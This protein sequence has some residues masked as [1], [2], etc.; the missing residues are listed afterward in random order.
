MPTLDNMIEKRLL[1]CPR[2]GTTINSD[3]GSFVCANANC[4]YSINPFPLVS[5]KPAFIDFDESVVDV[6]RLIAADGRSELKRNR[7]RLKELLGSLVAGQNKVAS[8]IVDK[9]LGLLRS[10]LEVDSAA[11]AKQRVRILVVGGATVGSGLDALYSD[12]EIDIIA[13]DV[14]S[15]P[16]VQFVADGHSIPLA[17]ASVDGVIV[18]A[19]LEHVTDPWMVSEEIHRVLRG[20]GI[21]YADTPFM[22]QVHEGPFDFTRFTDSGHRYLFRRFEHI[23]SGAV[24]GA[25]SAL[26][27]SIEYFARALTRSVR[28]GRLVRVCLFWLRSTD[29]LL[30]PKYSLDAASG[31]YFLGRKCATEIT[32]DAIIRYYQGGMR[33]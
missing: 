13:F 18:Q 3:E 20:G 15:S 24:A 9:M 31:V 2:C 10:D 1:I 11:N 21:V 4:Q 25:G 29:G 26:A 22:Q 14:Y 8:R 7:S 5:G 19:V 27:W 16:F 33:T 32:Q 23:E 6:S 28:V 12:T 17:D 30:D